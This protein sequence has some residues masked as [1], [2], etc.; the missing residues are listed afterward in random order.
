M[1]TSPLPEAITGMPPSVADDSLRNRLPVPAETRHFQPRSSDS[2]AENAGL[3]PVTR[4]N[5]NPQPRHPS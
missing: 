2:Q 5:Q 4:S 3:I 1:T